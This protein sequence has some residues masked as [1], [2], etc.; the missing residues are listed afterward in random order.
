MNDCY[1]DER[2]E[3]FDRV[4]SDYV[5]DYIVSDADIVQEYKY[6]NEVRNPILEVEVSDWDETG[7]NRTSFS[8]LTQTVFRDNYSD[9]FFKRLG[10]D[11]FTKLAAPCTSFGFVIVGF[12][13]STHIE[14]TPALGDVTC[15]WEL[16]RPF[17]RQAEVADLEVVRFGPMWVYTP[18]W[19]AEHIIEYAKMY[20]REKGD[21]I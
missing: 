10:L 6:L 13:R 17:V 18:L 11:I 16:L 9:I 4:I 12:K 7:V 2:S 3:A 15:V 21:E 20:C 1:G 8:F 5:D 19:D 14:V